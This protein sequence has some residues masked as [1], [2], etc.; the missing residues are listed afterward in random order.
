MNPIKAEVLTTGGL[1]GV[2]LLNEDQL[3]Q[4]ITKYNPTLLAKFARLGLRMAL[5]QMAGYSVSNI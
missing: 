3:L 4:V 2:T 5:H 1:Q